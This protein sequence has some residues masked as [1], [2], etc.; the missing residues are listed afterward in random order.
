M[1]RKTTYTEALAAEIVSRLS[2]GETLQ[3]ICR[4][5]GM[6][7]VRTVN[8][9]AQ[10]M[11]KFG[12]DFARARADGF[13]AIASEAK[14]IADTPVEGVEYVTKADGSTEERRGDMLGH[15]KLQ[16][17][18]R[19]KLLAKW[20]P[21]RYGEKQQIEHSG[22]IGIGERMRRAEERLKNGD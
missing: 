18:T 4:S 12:A 21:K 17:E 20:D 8:D 9:W 2:E 3:D 14:R 22:S 1:G 6:P 11:P 7:K 19:L 5:P 10:N 16:I 13:D 15:R